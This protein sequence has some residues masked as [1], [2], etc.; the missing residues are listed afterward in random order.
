MR[1]I[2]LTLL[3]TMCSVT[4]S[5]ETWT[6]DPEALHF[7]EF[8]VAL[9][10]SVDNQSEAVDWINNYDL[11]L[12]LIANYSNHLLAYLEESNTPAEHVLIAINECKQARHEELIGYAD[13]TDEGATP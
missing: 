5:Q 8:C 10:L 4:Q 6:T 1:T 9:F 11:D 12:S 7:P 13:P 2:L 3:L